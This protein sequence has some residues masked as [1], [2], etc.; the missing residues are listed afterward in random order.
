MVGYDAIERARMVINDLVALSQSIIILP[1]LIVT[2]TL[3]VDAVGMLI[4]I[5]ITIGTMNRDTNYVP[6]HM[7]A[8]KRMRMEREAIMTSVNGDGNGGNG[9][10]GDD[11]ESGDSS[12]NA[13]STGDGD[14]DSNADGDGNTDGD[15]NDKQ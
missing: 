9:G 7:S 11:Q 12:G 10:N 14:G 4:L 2:N 6:H 5:V 3:L 13:N 8:A 15:G 1:K